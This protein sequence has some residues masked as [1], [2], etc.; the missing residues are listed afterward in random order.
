MSDAREL[1]P[2]APAELSRSQAGAAA[3]GM[4]AEDA[5]WKSAGNLSSTII[6]HPALRSSRF[7]GY[8]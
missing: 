7:G 3:T 1:R 8:R 5:L 4:A 6:P 2:R